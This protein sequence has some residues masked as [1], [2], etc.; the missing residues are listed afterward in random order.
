M[1][2]QIFIGPTGRI[3]RHMP[4][5]ELPLP[6]VPEISL[7]GVVK[8]LRNVLKLADLSRRMGLADR[9]LEMLIRRDGGR[10]RTL[11]IKQYL[12]LLAVHRRHFPYGTD[13]YPL[14][15]T[16]LDVLQPTIHEAESNDPK[17][18]A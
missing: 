4:A 2:G 13:A 7:P 14:G 12:T 5:Y 8:D 16:D 1:S 10:A 17:E 3:R 6:E 15:S 11:S 18:N 9:C